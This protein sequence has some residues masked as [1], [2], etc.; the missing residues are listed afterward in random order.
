MQYVIFPAQF[1]FLYSYY[2]SGRM[3]DIAKKLNERWQITHKEGAEEAFALA[4]EGFVRETGPS[5]FQK[6]EQPE[7]VLMARKD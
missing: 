6:S 2:P 7:T 1:A 3:D 4:D 5:F